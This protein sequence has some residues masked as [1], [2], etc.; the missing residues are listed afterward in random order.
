MSAAQLGRAAEGPLSAMRLA[1]V[2][3][4]GVVLG[5]ASRLEEVTRGFSAGISSERTWVLAALLAGAVAA[6]GTGGLGGWGQPAWAEAFAT[7]SAWARVAG[8]G[9]VGGTLLLVSA[10]ASWYGWIALTETSVDLGAVAGPPERWFVLS[11]LA[12]VPA[13]GFGACVRAA[14]YARR[15]RRPEICGS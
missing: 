11:V 7:L 5:V 13:G 2:V 1:G 8:R 4:G 12:G 15:G 3:L 10:N 6:G 14:L 9:A